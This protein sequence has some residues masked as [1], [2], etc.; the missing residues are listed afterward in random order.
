MHIFFATIMQNHIGVDRSSQQLMQKSRR[1]ENGRKRRD[2]GKQLSD[3]GF[4]CSA[5]MQNWKSLQHWRNGQQIGN[6]RKFC[7]DTSTPWLLR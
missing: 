3:S 4:L 7:G 5:V 2:A 1:N 6:G